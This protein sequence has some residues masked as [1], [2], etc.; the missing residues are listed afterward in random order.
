[1][2][3][4][5]V[6]RAP[7]HAYLSGRGAKDYPAEGHACEK[8]ETA[9]WMNQLRQA[10]QFGAKALVGLEASPTDDSTPVDE[11]VIQ[12]ARDNY[13]LLRSARGGIGI[14]RGDQRYSGPIID[15]VFKRVDE[16]WNL[17]RVPVDR[18]SSNISRREYLELSIQSLRRSL[19]LVDQ[20]FVLMP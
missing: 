6:P 17:A 2:A 14:A 12:A 1:M 5:P 11:T 19:Q 20:V 7:A 8:P 18:I 10:R 9:W 15:L 13:V 3:R 16:A 4:A